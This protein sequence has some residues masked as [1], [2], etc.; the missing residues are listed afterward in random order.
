VDLGYHDAKAL[1]SDSHPLA[2]HGSP[3]W[4]E[5]LERLRK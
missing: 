1:E 5:F 4:A 2:H 3:G